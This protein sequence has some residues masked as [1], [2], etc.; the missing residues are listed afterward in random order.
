MKCTICEKL[1]KL[2]RRTTPVALRTKPS[3]IQFTNGLGQTGS[4]V[5]M[6]G[7]YVAVVPPDEAALVPYPTKITFPVRQP[8]EKR[9]PAQLLVMTSEQIELLKGDPN[10]IEQ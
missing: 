9:Q 4:I 2:V 1:A 8:F 5:D 3:P 10:W 6:G 7:G